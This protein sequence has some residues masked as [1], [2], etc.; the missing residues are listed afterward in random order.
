MLLD[1]AA[2]HGN[3]RTVAVAYLLESYAVLFGAP[4]FLSPLLPPTSAAAEEAA[5]N[6]RHRV[7]HVVQTPWRF[8]RRL[9]QVA[10]WLIIVPIVWTFAAQLISPLPPPWVPLTAVAIAAGMVLGLTGWVAA[11]TPSAWLADPSQRVL[12]LHS[13]LKHERAPAIGGMIAAV[14]LL[15][16][17]TLH[18]LHVYG[19][20]VF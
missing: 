16:A 5:K 17:I 9:R 10:A 13:A 19:A 1:L 8:A 4:A 3:H 20:W 15:I 6:R 18:I 7:G 11:L 14:V 12:T 2:T